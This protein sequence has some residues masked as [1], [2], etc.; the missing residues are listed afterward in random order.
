MIGMQVRLLP[1]VIWGG[2]ASHSHDEQLLGGQRLRER[3]S[4]TG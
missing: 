4:G 2:F 1:V 3:L